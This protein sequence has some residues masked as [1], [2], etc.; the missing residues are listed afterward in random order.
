MKQV[1]EV[2]CRPKQCSKW[3][4]KRI[5]YF[6]IFLFC[7]NFSGQFSIPCTES[8]CVEDVI[9]V[10]PPIERINEAIEQVA[11][12]IIKFDK[13]EIFFGWNATTKRANPGFAI[14]DT[15]GRRAPSRWSLITLDFHRHAFWEWPVSEFDPP[16]YPSKTRIFFP[17][18]L[19]WCL[20]PVL[21]SLLIQFYDLLTCL[22]TELP[23][24]F[25]L[26]HSLFTH[27]VFAIFFNLFAL[28][29]CST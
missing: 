8:E 27:L 23:S 2:K 15:K 21:F 7:T 12:M 13:N 11:Y 20:M 4:V 26:L 14:L 6:S 16:P 22:P 28:F 29:P 9:F 24:L 10:E 19:I 3:K 25:P 18:T 1:A 5:L 17:F